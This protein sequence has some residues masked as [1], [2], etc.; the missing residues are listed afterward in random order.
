MKKNDIAAVVLIVFFAGVISFFIASAVIG[1]PKNNPVEVEQV[2]PINANFPTPDAR[3]F[4]D[5]AIDPTVE[6]QGGGQ[7]ADT[8]FSN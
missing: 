3:V 6:V 1:K 8:P 7:P 2:T 4:N 5:K